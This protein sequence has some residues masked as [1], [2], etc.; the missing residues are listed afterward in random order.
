MLAPSARGAFAI[1]ISRGSG[2]AVSWSAPRS[3]A[4]TASSRLEKPEVSPPFADYT[5]RRIH[6][7]AAWTLARLSEEF[8]ST[9][10]TLT[11]RWLPIQGNL[12][13]S[14]ASPA[15]R[16]NDPVRGTV[17]LQ[18]LQRDPDAR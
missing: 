2:S 1:R 11:E 7:R 13:W 8:S 18:D 16:Q 5:G 14:G 4:S 6:R 9:A 15:L 3:A 12:E 10:G 17:S